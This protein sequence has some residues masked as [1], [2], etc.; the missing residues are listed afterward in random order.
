M[1]ASFWALSLQNFRHQF[2]RK[3][4]TIRSAVARKSIF[5]PIFLLM[6]GLS[7]APLNA[8]TKTANP[9]QFDGLVE[10]RTVESDLD[11][12]QDDGIDSSGIGGRV[13]L[14]VSYDLSEQT[15]V[16]AEGEG[17]IFDFSSNGRDS[18]ETTIGR[19][20]VTHQLSQTVQVRAYARRFENIAVLES[21]SADQTSLGTRVQWQ[22]GDNRVRLTG[23]YRERDYDTTVGGNS[24]GYRIAGQYNRRLGRYHWVRVDARVEDN[25]SIDEPF[26]SYERQGARIKY[27]Q[28]IAKRLRFRPSL[29]YRQ[30]DYDARIA[31]GDPNGA[32]RKDS[33]IAPAAEL[34][35]GRSNRGLY[36][37][38][39]AEYR[40][41]KSN[42]VRFDDDA[43][44]VGVRVGFRF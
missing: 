21:F 8:Q 23:E 43:V 3:T 12:D 14:G 5:G 26:R 38:A 11:F 6:F 24:D 1:R 32:L 28:P 34:A 39:S 41:K 22:D 37:S 20:Q 44:R 7:A 18:L 9:L 36:A 33:Y 15:T 2:Q 17:R 29:E 27:S 19:V 35:W 30:W 40:F 16:R 10:V 25:E 42:D 31:Q 13:R 4:K